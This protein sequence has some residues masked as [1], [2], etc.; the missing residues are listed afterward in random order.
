M[1]ADDRFTEDFREAREEAARHPQR[2]HHRPGRGLGDRLLP[3]RAGVVRRPLPDPGRPA[4]ALPDRAHRAVRRRLAADALRGRRGDRLRHRALL[5][6]VD[7]PEQLPAA[8]RAGAGRRLA[9][10]L[11]R[12]AVPPRRAQAAAPRVHQDGGR[13]AGAGDEG[14]LPFAD[15]HVRGTG[16]RRRRRR[17]R[18][19]HPDA[20]HRRHARLPAGGRAAVPGVRRGPAGGHQP[21]AGRAHRAGRPAVRLPAGAGPRPPRQPARGPHDLPDQRGT[22]RPASS[23]PDARRR[24]DGPAA[25]RRHRHD[26]ERDRRVAVAPGEEPG[27]PQR[28]WPPRPGCCRPRWRSSSGPTRR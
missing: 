16:R 24:H 2:D 11:L 4:A 14:V 15:R 28:A 1:T 10:D 26:L 13:Q 3:S 18:A 5:L 19:A 9:A 21:A 6:A 17:L 25:D 23:T 12:P 22:V 27:G 20:G 8:A 7:H